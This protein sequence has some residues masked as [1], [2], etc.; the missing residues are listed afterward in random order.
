MSSFG[1]EFVTDS[2]FRQ[3]KL[4]M[5][6]KTAVKSVTGTGFYWKLEPIST[7]DNYFLH[8]RFMSKINLKFGSSVWKMA[9]DIVI[10][11]SIWCKWSEEKKKYTYFFLL[12]ATRLQKET[13]NRLYQ[14]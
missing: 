1:A 7:L 11:L 6:F 4:N 12:Q 13:G 5:I 10:S 8:Y 9:I 14:K 2:G 3:L